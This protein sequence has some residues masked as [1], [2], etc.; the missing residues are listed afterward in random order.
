MLTCSYGAHEAGVTGKFCVRAVIENE[1]NP[2][3]RNK[4][5]ALSEQIRSAR[6]EFYTSQRFTR[7]TESQSTGSQLSTDVSLT[8]VVWPSSM[9]NSSHTSSRLR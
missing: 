1:D 4:T 5:V 9:M 6:T 3:I 7:F 2:G 8:A